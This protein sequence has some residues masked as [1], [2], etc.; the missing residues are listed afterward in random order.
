MKNKRCTGAMGIEEVA[1]EAAERALELRQV[2]D[3][4]ARLRKKKALNDLL[5]ALGALGLTRRRAAVPAHDRTVHAW[6]IQ[7]WSWCIAPTTLHHL[8]LKFLLANY[9]LAG[10]SFRMLLISLEPSRMQKVQ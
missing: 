6:F 5:K 1:G 2:T 8:H 7:V 10:N 4:G 9:V 3:K